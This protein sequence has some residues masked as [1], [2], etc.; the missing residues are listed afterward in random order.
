M[1][2]VKEK[3]TVTVLY[4]GMLEDG[5][6]FESSAETGPLSFEIG[7]GS[8]LPAFEAAVLGMKINETRSISLAADEAYGPRREELIITVPREKFGEIELGPGSVVAMPLEREGQT[9]KVPAT[10][11]AADELNVTVDFNHPLAGMTITYKITLQ[12]I[13]T[14]A[15]PASTSCGCAS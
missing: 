9:H 1:Q 6:V 3:D 8:V 2:Q 12:S 7:S 4:D 10:V 15:S 5:T 13:D 11:V 14:D